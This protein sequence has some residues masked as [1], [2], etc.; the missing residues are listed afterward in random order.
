MYGWMAVATFGILHAEV[1]PT[2]IVYWFFM[3]AGML[4][5]CLTAYPVNALRL[6]RGVK[7]AM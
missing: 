5:G 6:Q 4:A 3:Q 2:S 1:S 7:E